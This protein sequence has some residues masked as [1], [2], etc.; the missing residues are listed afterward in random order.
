MKIIIE[1]PPI[2]EAILAHRM[3][4]SE[5]TIFTYGD[6]IYNPNN[7]PISDDLMVHEE[8]HSK[9][10][11]HSDDYAEIWWGRYLVDPCFRIAQEVEAYA[12]QYDFICKK[13]N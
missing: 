8:V 11:N 9:Q 10:Q 4:P 3:T 6:T 1:K 13:I 7:V 12:N 2:Y 5:K